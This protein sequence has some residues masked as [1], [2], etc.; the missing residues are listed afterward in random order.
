MNGV[1][2][3]S[4]MKSPGLCYKNAIERIQKFARKHTSTKQKKEN[5]SSENTNNQINIKHNYISNFTCS[6]CLDTKHTFNKK[7][8]NYKILTNCCHVFHK[9]CIRTWLRH[10]KEKKCPICRCNLRDYEKIL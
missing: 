8:N 2:V 7:Q 1:E 5:I 3:C 6:I 10:S 9:Q 4:C